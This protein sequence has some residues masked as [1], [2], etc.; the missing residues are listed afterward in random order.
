MLKAPPSHK[1]AA[2]LVLSWCGYQGGRATVRQCHSDLV[3]A[4][5]TQISTC[6]DTADC[7]VL[8]LLTWRETSLAL[9]AWSV[10][11]LQLSMTQLHMSGVIMC[12]ALRKVRTRALKGIRIV[13]NSGKPACE[14][15][16][17]CL[18]LHEDCTCALQ[19]DCLYC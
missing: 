2:T 12:P 10:R 15:F 6:L 16:S 7:K 19:G 11:L 14:V 1:H 17:S 3:P 18:A 5:G 13:A 4:T 9:V 8:V